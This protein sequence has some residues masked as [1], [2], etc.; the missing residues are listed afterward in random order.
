MKIL[1]VGDVI[2]RPGRRIVHQKLPDLIHTTEASLVILNCENSAA[3][4][5]VTAEIAND[6][7]DLGVDVLTSGNHIWDKRSIFDY[8]QEQPRLLRPHNYPDAPGSGIFIG[9]T[10]EAVRYAVINVQGRTYLPAINCPFRTVDA[11]LDRLDAD[12]KVVFVDFHAEVTSEKNALGCYLD[13]RVSAVVGTHTHV[14]TADERVLPDGTAYQTDAGMTGPIE[15]VIGMDKEGSLQRFLTG[16]NRRFEP[17]GGPVWLNG[18]VIDVDESTG[19]ARSIRRV[20]E[21]S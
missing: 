5:G 15:S 2:G 20:R 4:F 13:G 7:L 12:I 6:F 19:R 10:S 17:A 18:C 11:L 14:P 16:I 9:A 3:G 21:T 1:F 8:I